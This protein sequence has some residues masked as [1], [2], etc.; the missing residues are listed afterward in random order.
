VIDVF[1]CG[2]AAVLGGCSA[3]LSNAG[4][5]FY[6]DALR[7]LAPDL[8]AGTTD[9][10]ELARYGWGV[11]YRFMAWFGL[12]F[13]L[14]SGAVVSHLVFLPAD[15]IGV[16]VP[17]RP[18]A[19]LSAAATA[20]AIFG[21]IEI[22]HSALAGLSIDVVA[23][24]HALVQ[25]ILWLYPTIP[26]VAALKL[27]SPRRGAAVVA[28]V[29]VAIA[30]ALAVSGAAHAVAPASAIAGLLTL[31]ALHMTVLGVDKGV[32][33]APART[34]TAA[35]VRVRNALRLLLFVGASV[36]FL[37]HAHRLAGEPMAAMLIGSGKAV[38][39]AAVALMTAVAFFPL[40]ALSS[41]AADSYAT[42]G[43]PDW[44]PAFGYVAPTA[45]AAAAGGAALMAIEA[46]G[47]QRS[48]S[49]LIR[50]PAISRI[51]AAMRESLGDVALL[52]LL[53]GGFWMAAR[54][55]AGVGVAVVA[56]AWF[57]NEQSG[58]PVTRLAVAPSAAILVG[59]GANLW[60]LVS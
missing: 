48:V 34:T 54:L 35:G 24:A 3:A 53:I 5:A 59:I 49:L 2:V 20:A 57:L 29:E 22:A 36:A 45:G 11:S 46:L 37:A 32:P 14:L 33:A 56:A 12:P 39:A 42:Q 1:N 10:H 47:A 52:A 30:G 55:G 44:I 7:P 31:I 15:I 51:A 26:F 18:L 13:S 17:S 28:A 19:I 23:S 38:D 6:H 50:R 43:T 4:D 40:V 58:T 9:R 8:R 27:A 21:L 16:R 41:S 25:P 60:H